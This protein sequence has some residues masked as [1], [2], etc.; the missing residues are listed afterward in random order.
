ML[1][2]ERKIK[3]MEW[4]RKDGFV[5]IRQL[6]DV[7]DISR[8]SAMRDLDEL[9]QQGLIVR[10]RGGAS[11]FETNELLSQFNEPAQREKEKEHASEKQ[12]ICRE[13]AKLV[14][15][16]N[17]IYID[18]GTTSLHLIDY[19]MDKKITIVTPN[20]RLLSLIPDD[21]KGKVI[22]LGGDYTPKYDSVAGIV[23]ASQIENFHFDY[24]FLTC[25]GLNLENGDVS[26][27]HLPYA[28][29]KKLVMKKSEKCELL[30]D[31]SKT[32]VKGLC[33]YAN[34]SMFDTIFM[35]AFEDES[36][37]ENVVICE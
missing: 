6:M 9:E 32:K 20:V 27:F 34:V 17:N 36:L 5:S 7:L 15:N 33:T 23:T 25:N 10:Q 12:W 8:S 13:A 11:L 30:V 3:I 2:E 18:A 14:K 24:A 22:L 37:P 31:A 19:L 26:S 1:G 29:N 16:G 21:F 4:I 35:N 28:M